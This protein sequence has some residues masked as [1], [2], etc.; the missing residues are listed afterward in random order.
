MRIPGEGTEQLIDRKQECEVY[1]V[2]KKLKISD[3]VL[4]FSE[5]EGYKL[6]EFIENAHCCDLSNLEEVSQCMKFLRKFHQN[7]EVVDNEFNLWEK[8]NFYE[9]LWNGNKSCYV[10]YE[11]TK[12]KINQLLQYVES[13]PKRKTLC[14]IDAVPDNFLISNN[15]AGDNTLEGIHL[16]DWEYASMQDPDIAMF[17]IYSIYNKEMVDWLINSYYQGECPIETRVKIYCY[18]AASGLLW[19]NWCEYKMQKGVDFGEYSIQQYRYAKQYFKYVNEML[20][21][22]NRRSVQ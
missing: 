19:S 17:A 7:S 3:N 12:N 14:H 15:Y 4:Y 9:N 5:N 18:I 16:I 2:I 20:Y 1:K 10:D 13:I 21:E 11:E 22:K 8:I 6:T